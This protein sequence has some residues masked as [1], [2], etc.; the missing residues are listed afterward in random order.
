[1][2]KFFLILFLFSTFVLYAQVELGIDL[3]FKEGDTSFLENKKIGIITNHTGVNSSLKSTVDVFKEKAVNYKIVAIFSPE[4]GFTGSAYAGEKLNHTKDEIPIYSLHGVAKRP[5]PE[6]LKDI[7]VLIYDLQETGV[8]PYT[9]FSTL[10]Y[11]MEEAAKNNIKVIVLDRPNPINGVIVDGPMLEEAWRSFLGYINVAYCHGM[12][13]GELASFFNEEYK[14]GCDLK[15]VLMKGWNRS[16]SYQDTGLYWT[17]TSPNIPEP[18]TPIY[19]ATTGMLGELELVS[20]GIGYTLPFKIV[21]A[22]WIKAEEFAENLNKQK[23]PGV[24]F[25]P[26]HF[27]PF[28][29]PYKNEECHGVRII[30]TDL[31]VYKPLTTQYFLISILKSLYPKEV[32]S[33]LS[34]IKDAKKKTFCQVCGSELLL[35]AIINEKYFAYKLM[36][37]QEEKQKQFLQKREKYLLY[38]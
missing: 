16:M 33:R 5:T 37:M 22:P 15:V 31:A 21:G 28:M 27:K 1:M 35:D 8:R 10:C 23:L 17:P 29:V 36:Q 12:T 13:I 7:D 34:K 2:R 25:V 3:F 19:N 24:I 18:N 6:M 14:I 30:I 20:I 11:V 38:K 26:F 9:Y 32:Q 4:H